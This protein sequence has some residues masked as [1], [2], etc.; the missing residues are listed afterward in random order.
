MSSIT[1]QP[2]HGAVVGTVVASALV[3]VS[4]TGGVQGAAGMSPCREA[5]P[6]LD[7]CAHTL[8]A[9]PRSTFDPCAH[10][11][12]LLTP[13]PLALPTSTCAKHFWMSFKVGGARK[14]YDVPYPHAYAPEKN[15]HKA[16]FDCVQR[17]HQVTLANKCCAAVQAWAA[18]W[19][20]AAAA[21]E[22]TPNT[23][24]KPLY[25]TPWRT[26]PPSWR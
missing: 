26:S 20:R 14:K 8:L 25:R 6:H 12:A 16:Q 18:G 7:V 4:S 23:H 17:A 11:A 5:Q 13:Q 9:W 1:L 15:A 2:A 21:P 24:S 10:L 22:L 19:E 3:H